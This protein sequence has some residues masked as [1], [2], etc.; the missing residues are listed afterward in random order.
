MLERERERE[1]GVRKATGSY[2]TYSIPRK[3]TTLDPSRSRF[4]F[5]DAL[6]ISGI[7]VAFYSEREKSDKFCSEALISARDPR[8]YFPSEGSHTQDFYALKKSI[9]P[10]RV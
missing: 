7:S 2:R 10:D 5:Y 8:L 9:G 3:T 4:G 6:N 1:S